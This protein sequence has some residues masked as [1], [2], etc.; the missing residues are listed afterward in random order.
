MKV[1]TKFKY[2]S[3]SRHAK[4]R[5]RARDGKFLPAPDQES[6][7]TASTVGRDGEALR[8][9]CEEPEEEEQPADKKKYLPQTGSQKPLH[10]ENGKGNL[11]DT[12]ILEGTHDATKQEPAAASKPKDEADKMSVDSAEL[13]QQIKVPQKNPSKIEP[14]NE[15]PTLNRNDSLF[16]TK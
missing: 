2:V 15:E 10:I 14:Q 1:R 5:K 7:H 12:K 6:S 13:F 3:R 8:A 11:Q 4:N 9:C 16:A